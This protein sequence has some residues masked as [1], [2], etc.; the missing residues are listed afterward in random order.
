MLNRSDESFLNFKQQLLERETVYGLVMLN[1]V[2]SWAEI[3]A[4]TGFDF[5][6]IDTEHTNMT[7][8]DVEKLIIAL[9]LHGCI[10]LVRVRSN[11]LNSIGQVLDLG[12]RIVTIPHIDTAEDARKAVYGA[13]Y[14]PL[15][16]RGYA[17]VSRS[18][19]HGFRRLDPAYMEKK[20]NETMLMVQIESEEAVRNVEEI[21]LI[22][23]VDILFV[24]YADLC[25]DMG[26][27]ADPAH[28]RCVEAIETVGRA[29]KKSGKI[30]AF[31]ASDPE[32]I[33]RY[34]ELGFTMIIAGLETTLFRNAAEELMRKIR[35]KE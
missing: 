32:K 30:G 31:V 7:F 6:W 9:E 24:G 14:Y 26:I 13:K 3:I 4:M 35:Q 33:V 27:T 1:P 25:Q 17:T 28:P 23:G 22:D 8:H 19:H 16:R 21:A 10:P 12:A 20:N 18:T 34:R 29:L 15:G 11:E 5:A 2:A